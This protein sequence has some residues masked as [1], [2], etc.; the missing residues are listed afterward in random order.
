MHMLPILVN[1]LKIAAQLLFSQLILEVKICLCKDTRKHSCGGRLGLSRL[2]RLQ[3]LT[4]VSTLSDVCD[5]LIE[6]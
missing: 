2:A 4:Y 5:A 6:M 1:D 3:I